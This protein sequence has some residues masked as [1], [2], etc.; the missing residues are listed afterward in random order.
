MDLGKAYGSSVEA[1]PVLKVA[2]N[3]LITMTICN[4]KY[5][6]GNSYDGDHSEDRLAKFVGPRVFC[7][8]KTFQS[9]SLC[10]VYLA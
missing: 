6:G 5:N 4:H 9:C 3:C 10:V 8:S 1:T 7:F 2:Q